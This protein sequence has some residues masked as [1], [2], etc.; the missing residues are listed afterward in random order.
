MVRRAILFSIPFRTHLFEHNKSNFGAYWTEMHI[1]EN[2][3]VPCG[4]MGV[5][6]GE[7]GHLKKRTKKNESIFI[8]P[9]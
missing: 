9:N 3:N 7:R 2:K 6:G 4:L 8:R 5:L 1:A